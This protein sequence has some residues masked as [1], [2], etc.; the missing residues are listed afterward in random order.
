MSLQKF[1]IINAVPFGLA[2]LQSNASKTII[3]LTG[4]IGTMD[5]NDSPSLARLKKTSKRIAH[6]PSLRMIKK[7]NKLLHNNSSSH[8]SQEKLK[9]Q[10]GLLEQ[11]LFD[12]KMEKMRLFLE[13]E[14]LKLRCSS[15]EEENNFLRLQ[16]QASQNSEGLGVSTDVHTLDDN[17]GRTAEQFST[18]G[19]TDIATNRHFPHIE[20]LD[21]FCDTST[22]AN[23]TDVFV[24]PL[25]QD[26]INQPSSTDLKA[27]ARI[28][29]HEEEIS[30]EEK[31][32]F[33][34]EVEA[35]QVDDI[36]F[37]DPWTFDN[38]YEDPDDDVNFYI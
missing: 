12:V 13:N 17:S 36:S 21:E 5:N 31:D 27:G 6:A 34:E 7:R 3:N 26:I 30:C 18:Q 38:L 8:T 32:D 25:S 29:C 11:Q 22:W 35:D 14:D 9:L 28:I 15:L 24:V 2:R 23:D 10:R 4:G 33:M 19:D 20:A 1:M 16:L 37:P